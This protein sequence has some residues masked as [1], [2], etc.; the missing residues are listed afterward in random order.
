ME[1]M[2]TVVFTWLNKKGLREQITTR[3]AYA[4]E[5]AMELLEQEQI[6]K[7]RDIYYTVNNKA[8]YK[9]DYYNTEL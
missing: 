6:D 5:I 4:R 2:T 7:V 3:F 1:P 9:L 8:S